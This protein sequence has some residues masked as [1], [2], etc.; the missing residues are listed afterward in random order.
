M[1]VA[2]IGVNY[3]SAP[4]EVRERLAIAPPQLADALRSFLAHPNVREGWILSTCNRVEFLASHDSLQPDLLSFLQSYFSIEASA[5]RPH[6]YEYREQDAMLHLFRV[7]ASLDSMVVGEPQILGQVRESYT[8]ARSV[9]AVSTELDQ[10][11]QRALLVGRKVR[12]QTRVGASPV[13]IASVAVDMAEKIFGSLNDKTVCVVGAGKMSDLAARHLM[14]RGAS[15][16]LIANRTEAKAAVIAANFGGEVLPFAALYDRLDEADIIITSTGS[17]QPLFLKEHGAKFMARRRGRPMFFIDIA[18][19]R[20]VD[21][22]MSRLEGVFVYDIDDLQAVAAQH[23][24]S[25][26]GEAQKAESIIES[27][28]ASFQRKREAL[29][30]TPTLLTVRESLESL[31][32]SELDRSRTRLAGLSEEQR[33]AVDAM[34]RDLLNKVAHG[35][36]QVLK[37]AAQDNDVASVEA[38]RRAFT[39]N[40]PGAPPTPEDPE[41]DA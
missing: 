32:R 38:I 3:K 22:A 41:R 19:P 23:A 9:G 34:T 2:L 7:A 8:V 35:P 29:E 4:V 40:A 6:I 26:S 18:V 11:L 33:A 10:L 13:S 1:S 20:D 14:A 39:R 5:I 24:L 17:G 25:R 37:T 15:R 30:I 36:M 16:L 31:R 21:P 27:E 12:N 28:V